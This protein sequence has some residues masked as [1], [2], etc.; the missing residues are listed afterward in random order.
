ML[1]RI[2]RHSGSWRVPAG[3]LALM[4]AMFTFSSLV[5]GPALTGGDSDTAKPAKPGVTQPL[6]AGHESH[7]G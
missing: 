7:H 5:I 4:A 3:L 6:P 2:R 1:R